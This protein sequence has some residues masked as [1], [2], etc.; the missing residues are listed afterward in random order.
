MMVTSHGISTATNFLKRSDDLLLHTS[1]YLGIYG[2]WIFGSACF[3][4]FL[5]FDQMSL[6]LCSFK[7]ILSLFIFDKNE[8]LMGLLLTCLI[9]I[10]FLFMVKI[11]SNI[12]ILRFITFTVGYPLT[13]SLLYVN[14]VVSLRSS[15]MEI[16]IIHLSSLVIPLLFNTLILFSSLST[17]LLLLI[18][19]FL[20]ATSIGL[21]ICLLSVLTTKVEIEPLIYRIFIASLCGFIS[22]ASEA[23]TMHVLYKMR[24]TGCCRIIMIMTIVLRPLLNSSSNDFSF[25]NLL[26]YA[27]HNYR[28]S[29]SQSISLKSKPNI[30]S[31]TENGNNHND[32]RR[33]EQDQQSI[34]EKTQHFKYLNTQSKTPLFN[35][36]CFLCHCHGASVFWE[37]S[38]PFS[39]FSGSK[40]ALEAFMPSISTFKSLL[41]VWFLSTPPKHYLP[42]KVMD[43]FVSSISNN[44]LQI[45]NNSRS[46]LDDTVNDINAIRI[47][48]RLSKEEILESLN[49]VGDITKC[50]GCRITSPADNIL[51]R[52][53]DSSP[54]DKISTDAMMVDDLYIMEDFPLLVSGKY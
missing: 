29:F 40:L 39:F 7:L 14:N 30:H 27:S 45:T 16:H 9:Y 37:N 31:K 6:I 53:L 22:C 48:L 5:T 46:L 36:M 42:S 11:T 13:L 28:Q 34:K 26:H 54:V 44:K 15:Q 20:S 41:S 18:S 21:V 33:N 23:L 38:K 50:N 24:V 4:I 47:L 32:S 8:T 49:M 35:S 19:F 12:S 3:L 25:E 17:Q 51:F 52:N 1:R 43:D 2:V 10:Y